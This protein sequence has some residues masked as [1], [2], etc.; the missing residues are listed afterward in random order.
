MS[1]RDVRA[2]KTWAEGAN[3]MAATLTDPPYFTITAWVCELREERSARHVGATDSSFPRPVV[4]IGRAGNPMLKTI[5]D[6]GL[7]YA[8]CARWAATGT[9]EVANAW[10]WVLGVPM[11]AGTGYVLKIGPKT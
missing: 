11:V 4:R 3:R 10:F 2:P 1:R 9:L 7:F 5:L 6:T 8:R